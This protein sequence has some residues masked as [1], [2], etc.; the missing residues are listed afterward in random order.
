M[1]RTSDA[2]R[3]CCQLGEYQPGARR[4]LPNDAYR[5]SPLITKCAMT[6]VPVYNARWELNMIDVTCPQCG[7]VYHS[8]QAHVGKQL[9]CVK[10][11]SMVPIAMM[12]DRTVVQR[13]PTVPS[14]KSH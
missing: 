3:L 8:E 12:T 5:Q 13:G 2:T 4:L 1:G 14:A 11:G 6:G 9:R 10:C 7:V